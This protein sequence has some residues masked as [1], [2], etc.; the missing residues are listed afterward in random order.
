MTN[1]VLLQNDRLRS[2]KVM[3]DGKFKQVPLSR[4]SYITVR[5]IQGAASSFPVFFIKNPETGQFSIICLFGF[6]EGENL[7]VTDEGWQ[8]Q[9]VPL[10]IRRMPFALGEQKK[11][12]GE[13][14]SV[15]L[16]DLDDCRV[17][18]EEGRSLFDSKGQPSE[19]LQNK[20][21]ILKALK[22]GQEE[23]A[24]FIGKLL[25]LK[26]IAPSTFDVTFDDGQKRRVE[27]LY[28]INQKGLSSL[29]DETVLELYRKN[30]FEYIYMI[31]SSL[32]QMKNLIDL[33]NSYFAKK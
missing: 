9:Y 33:K 8:S 1:F 13:A 5:E 16:L 4:N 3:D 30:Y 12:I 27:G 11:E 18:E 25:D 20:I 32:S 19:F 28:T 2:I 26:L 14:E 7:Y 21:S 15:V 29:S 23:N 6:D 10:N 22:D 17:G 31:I 24:E